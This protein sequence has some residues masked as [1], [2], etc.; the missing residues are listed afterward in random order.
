[1]R[2]QHP[3]PQADIPVSLRILNQLQGA[4]IDTGFEKEEWEIA[5]MAIEEW[6]RRH[7]PDALAAPAASGYQW[8]GLFLPDGTV[9]R[10][11]FGGK[12]SHSVVE[13]D[14][15]L[16]DGKPVSPS[17]FVNAVGGIRRNAWLCTWILFPDTKQ[18][19]LADSLRTRRSPSSRRTQKRAPEPI[20]AP[21]PCAAVNAP[22][23][24]EANL[25]PSAHVVPPIVV[26]SRSS[27]NDRV[28]ALIRQELL[29][30]LQQL[31]TD[32]ELPLPGSLTSAPPP[33]LQGVDTDLHN[34]F[35]AASGPEIGPN[36]GRDQSCS[37]GIALARATDSI[38]SA[39]YRPINSLPCGLKWTP[40]GSSKPSTFVCDNRPY[41]SLIWKPYSIANSTDKRLYSTRSA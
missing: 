36:P 12:N 40:S 8:K 7:D 16:F 31:R 10:T 37:G 19:A 33:A 4:S 21:Q 14:R 32:Q 2:R 23:A 35:E 41:M 38:A 11:V 3:H 22:L 20:L 5:E 18:W 9:L 25:N 6:V 34:G 17:G 28:A 26:S 39:M 15:I 24:H 13:G 27:A 1:M 30:L 29:A